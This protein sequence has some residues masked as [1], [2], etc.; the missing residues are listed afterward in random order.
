MEYQK[1]YGQKHPAM[2]TTMGDLKILKEKKLEQIRRVI[3]S[4]KNEY[5]LAKASEENFRRFAGQTKSE[6]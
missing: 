1:K 6:T 4:I 5:E 2:V 3:E